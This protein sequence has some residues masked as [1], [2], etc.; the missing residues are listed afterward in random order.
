[1]LFKKHIYSRLLTFQPQANF[2]I[3]PVNANGSPGSIAYG[4]FDED[5]KVDI[6]VAL[7]VAGQLAIIHNNSTFGSI[8]FSAP[9][10]LPVAGITFVH[11]RDLDNDGKLDLMVGGPFL[12]AVYKNQNTIIG[13]PS[14]ALDATTPQS[15]AAQKIGT[16]E[17]GLGDLNGD[18]LL[19]I[20]TNYYN[21]LQL[22]LIFNTTVNN[23]LSFSPIKVLSGTGLSFSTPLVYSLVPYPKPQ[24]IVL[25]DVDGDNRPDMVTINSLIEGISVLK[26]VASVP[27]ITS[28]TPLVG[29]LGTQIN[30]KGKYFN[31]VANKNVVF[32]GAAMAKVEQVV[33][34]DELIILMPNGADYGFI[35]LTNLSSNLSASYTKGFDVT[36]ETSGVISFK[37]AIVN[38]AGTTP[39][40]VV[41]KDLNKDGLVDFV[42]GSPGS[43]SISIL[44]N[45][46]TLGSPNFITHMIQ[47]G[48]GII[49]SRISFADVDGDGRED[50]MYYNSLPNDLLRVQL[51][52]T[53]VTSNSNPI[54]FTT[55]FDI[56]VTAKDFDIAD[57]DGDGKPDIMVLTNDGSNQVVPYLNTSTV[58]LPSF[59]QVQG[60]TVDA[61]SNTI[62]VGDMDNDGQ[63]DVVVSSG[64]AKRITIL[65]NTSIAGKISFTLNQTNNFLMSNPTG[66][67]LA[68]LDNDGLTDIIM[69]DNSINGLAV[70]K[71]LSNLS[72]SADVAY[73]TGTNTGSENI[74]VGDVDG[75]G[76]P[77]IFLAYPNL[78][79]L[80]I[81]KNNY[82]NGQLLFDPQILLTSGSGAFGTALADVDG[83]LDLVNTN[84]F[85]N[86]LSVKINDQLVPV[87]VITL[88]ATIIGSAGDFEQNG[89]V[90]ANSFD[91]LVGFIF[92]QQVDLSNGNY[93]SSNS[94]NIITAGSGFVPQKLGFAGQKPGQYYYQMVAR[95]NAHLTQIFKGAILPVDIKANVLSFKTIS[96]NPVG[97]SATTV[98]YEIV[99]SGKVDGLM[100]TNFSL[101]LT[102]ALQNPAITQ[103]VPNP[104]PTKPNSWLITVNIGQPGN[105]GTLSLSLNNDNGL[106]AHVSGLPLKSEVYTI[107]VKPSKPLNLVAV[108][109]NGQVQLSWNSNPEANVTGYRIFMDTNPNPTT[110]L[111]A[112]FN[113]ALGY[114]QK[115][116]TNGT[117]YYYRI[118][119][120]NT[121]N[122]ESVYSDEVSATPSGN[123]VNMANQVIT[124][125][126]PTDPTY[127]DADIAIGAVSDSGLGVRYTS[128]DA[129]VAAIVNNK[130]H[131][132]GA[133]TVKIVASQAG[134]GTYYPAVAMARILTVNKL[135]ISVT[136]NAKAKALGTADPVFTYSY[137]PALVAGDSFNGTLTR[138]T[139][140][141]AGSYSILQ[142]A[143]SLGSNYSITFTGASLK[144]TSLQA[145]TITFAPLNAKTYGDADFN[146]TA[147]ANSG[148]AVN[149]SSRDNNIVSII[150]GKL[151]IVHPGTVTIYANQ[152]GNSQYNAATQVS[153]TVTVN[154]L[155]LTV[156]PVGQ[157]KVYG[158]ADAGNIV[159]SSTPALFAGDIFTGSLSRV[160]G[161]NAG[162]YTFTIGSLSAGND[163]AISLNAANLVIT[164]VSITI[165][166]DA[167]SKK[168]NDVDTVVT[169]QVTSGAL[170]GSDQ[171]I[172][173]LDRVARELVGTY[174]IQ[175]GSLSAGQNYALTFVPASFVI[176][177]KPFSDFILDANNLLTPNGDG[178]N[179]KLVIKHLDEF[180]PAKLTVVDREGRVVFMSQNYQNEFDG[181]YNGS[182]LAPNTYYY[183]LDFGQGFGRI[184]NY[185][186]IVN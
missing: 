145:Q 159:Y 84:L 132:I 27:I 184:K 74:S 49:P 29:P 87:E 89:K 150:N 60:I 116:L 17:I 146:G 134:D 41:A 155:A 70:K 86:N 185:I 69:T 54:D 80:A 63:I 31:T 112:V 88:P 7:S 147:T 174:A 108:A 33:S 45:I 50:W 35:S 71:N 182:P 149:Y 113:S 56:H 121:N 82:I 25:V 99:F 4:D 28:A 167:A 11:S 153:Q 75:D 20:V 131:I 144:I 133:G 55:I 114:L 186:T 118:T 127:G 117:T 92:G 139:G 51:N 39:N 168:I 172:G 52:S 162:S 48:S 148:L 65:K 57:F 79:K 136:A 137:T 154:K 58:G 107:Y 61:K 18:G 106:S 42:V 12:L 72:F 3:V 32:V 180:P 96:A 76:K 142:G 103:V 66:I 93:F 46:S 165:T 171:F 104:D 62:A 140:E 23:Q 161:E 179:D 169:Y 47:G 152:A 40:Y 90:K 83:R 73:A 181:T 77:D 24:D 59:S 120:V 175:I 78:T 105:N 157:S 130:L 166:A 37:S 85:A 19:D 95:N 164:P 176:T 34:S 177:L 5:G 143:L 160:A 64:T 129:N 22:N 13:T 126:Q 8:N 97:I 115:G 111:A 36:Y 138:I 53:D 9:V 1:M 183:I 16:Y 119:A 170:L 38:S 21:G 68:D 124:F 110:A 67:A 94:N 44:Q 10:L 14:F 6:A 100:A 128:S 26:N 158:T 91:V 178:K 151:H 141:S 43:N 98:D 30:L 101:V 81:F 122:L 2:Q 156:T 125:G 123:I 15:F 173:A 135:A 163:Y 109:Q 102:G